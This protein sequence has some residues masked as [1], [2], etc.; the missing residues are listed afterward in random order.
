MNGEIYKVWLKLD[1]RYLLAADALDLVFLYPTRGNQHIKRC[2]SR[3]QRDISQ[4]PSIEGIIISPG[5]L[6]QDSPWLWTAR[7]R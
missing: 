1:H 2:N 3:L 4:G 5:A 6:V 7:S